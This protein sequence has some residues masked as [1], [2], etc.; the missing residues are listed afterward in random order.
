MSPTKKE[1]L[2]ITLAEEDLA[3]LR[4]VHRQAQRAGKI[5]DDVTLNQWA[6]ALLLRRARDIDRR[7][8]T[9]PV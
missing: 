6:L 5:P 9:P 2:T 7:L 3:L 1:T 4:R 8:R